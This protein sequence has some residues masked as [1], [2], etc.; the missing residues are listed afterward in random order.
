MEEQDYIDLQTLLAKLRVY[1]LKA[2]GNPNIETSERER[3]YKMIRNVDNIRQQIPLIV[4]NGTI[5]TIK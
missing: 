3:N 2:I 4:D 5:S 1:C